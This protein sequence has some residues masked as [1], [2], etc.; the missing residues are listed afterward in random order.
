M[1]FAF[2]FAVFNLSVC[3]LTPPTLGISTP[4]TELKIN[5]LNVLAFYLPNVI[6]LLKWGED[7]LSFRFF[8]VFSSDDLEIVFVKVLMQGKL[9]AVAN[10]LR[11]Y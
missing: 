4:R 6:S 1:F 7:K 5:I 3:S 9:I 10:T 8:P 11:T 2:F